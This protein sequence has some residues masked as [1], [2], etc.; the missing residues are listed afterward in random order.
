MAA[1]A[2]TAAVIVEPIK[3]IKKELTKTSI[4]DFFQSPTLS[5]I[6]IINPLTGASYK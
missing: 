2:T 4:A 6:T 5:D 3:D 1:A